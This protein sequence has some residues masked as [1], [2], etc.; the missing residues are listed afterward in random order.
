LPPL[1]VDPSYLSTTH[2]PHQNHEFR[3]TLLITRLKVNSYAADHEFRHTLL[4]TRLKVNSYATGGKQGN[5]PIWIV[6]P[7]AGCQGDGIFMV[8]TLQRLEDMMR[9]RLAQGDF[10]V[11]GAL[12]LCLLRFLHPAVHSAML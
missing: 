6:K 10:V 1:E 2:F 7:T 8:D 3:H 4:I 5:P 12:S 11:C 9:T